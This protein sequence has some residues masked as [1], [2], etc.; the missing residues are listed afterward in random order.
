[1]LFIIHG[2]ICLQN[3]HRDIESVLTQS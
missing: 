2:V 3:E 1:M